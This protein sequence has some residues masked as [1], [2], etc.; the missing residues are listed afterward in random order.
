MRTPSSTL[1]QTACFA[2]GV[3][4]LGLLNSLL[5]PDALSLGYNYF[6][7]GISASNQEVGATASAST[8]GKSLQHGF[9]T[10]SIDDV[11]SYLDLLYEDPPFVVLLDARSASHYEAGHIPGAFLLDQFRQDDTIDELLPILKEA[12]IIVVYCT[13][14]ECEDSIF[15]STSL[16]Y[17]HGIS[18]DDISIFEG[19][20]ELWEQHGYELKEGKQR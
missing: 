2:T 12:A 18:A 5:N 9:A 17:N 1:A 4:V 11:H 3:L 7:T 14:G 6:P 13:G 20:I 15:L 10:K 16:V 8:N 19:G